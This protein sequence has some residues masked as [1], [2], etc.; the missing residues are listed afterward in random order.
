[1]NPQS[2]DPA[3]GFLQ[4]KDVNIRQ[5]I[6]QGGLWIFLGRWLM[7]G[8]GIVS[9][10]ILA[11]MLAPEDFGLVAIC[12]LVVGLAET[13]GFTGQNMAVIRR[14]NLDRAYTDS[15]WTVSILTGFILG[16]V[17]VASAPLVAGYFNEPR[18]QVLIY[19]LSA[20][21]FMM[22]FQNIG[23][24]LN[25]KNFNFARDFFF[26][27]LEK[28]IPAALTLLAAY[29]FRNY[30]ALVI[31][32]I[33]GYAALIIMS[34]VVFDYRPRICFKHA[35]EVWSFSIWV[36]VEKFA[37]FASMR[38][39]QI[40][41]PSIGA[42]T[43]VGLYHVGSELGRMP[44]VE[45]FMPIDRVLVPAYSRL[46]SQPSELANTYLN[47]LAVALIIC[48]PVSIGFA[49]V[50]SDAVQL[51]YGAKWV[52]MIPVVELI[53]LSSFAVALISTVTPLLQVLGRSRMSSGLI[54]LQALLL[55][56]GMLIFRS[57]FDSLSDIAWVRLV[58]SM[59]TLPVAII[60]VRNMITI[61]FIDILKIFWRPAIAVSVMALVLLFVLPQDMGMP[62]ILRMILRMAAGGLIYAVTLMLL[63]WLADK[64]PGA[65]RA[66]SKLIMG[67]LRPGPG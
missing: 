6:T 12:L 35:S 19:I 18:S 56:A 41:V 16:G 45:L 9:T 4:Q 5:A 54:C 1:M 13:I 7:R 32:A 58:I 27:I 33:T 17:V 44:V 3:N 29:F 40:F 28:V 20:R 60:L 14:Q 51:I 46:L 11:R 42:A 37:F 52:P 23:I 15:A 64:P 21:V 30:W 63:W 2:L 31:G 39:D 55:L 25:R 26:N 34:Y 59:L 8:I 43:E 47:T 66:L 53:A 62:M 48:L 36:V 61:R 10:I 38:I 50:A 67:R 57:D 49:M 22:G 65:E 24:A